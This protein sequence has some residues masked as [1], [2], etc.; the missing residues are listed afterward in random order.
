MLVLT[1][2]LDQTIRIGD[3]IS[4]TGLAVDRDQVR[5]GISAPRAVPIH[6][7]EVFEEIQAANRAAAVSE[8]PDLRSLQADLERPGE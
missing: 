3:S 1:R 5:I 8:R 7:Q 2:K 6:R 4:V